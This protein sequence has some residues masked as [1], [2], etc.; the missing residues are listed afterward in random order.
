MKLWQELQLKVD[1]GETM[2]L[3]SKIKWAFFYGVGNWSFYKKE[4]NF[5]IM[6][7]QGLYYQIK[8]KELKKEKLGLEKKLENGLKKINSEK[9][10]SKSLTFL[11]EKLYLK[12][13]MRKNRKK[14]AK[15]ALWKQPNLFLEEYPIILSTTFSSIT[16]L[17]SEVVYDYLI[18]DEASQV[19]LATGSLALACAKNVVV[20]GDSKQLPNVIT[21][22][23]KKR[24]EEIFNSYKIA[25]G[26]KN[27]KS[28]LQSILEVIP[29]IPQVLLKEHY[30]CHPKII[31]FCNQKFYGGK[32]V[33][34]TED[35]G[36]KNV[37]SVL[38][39][40]E[41]NHERNHYSQRQVDV[42]KKEV[43]PTFKEDPNNIGIIAPYNN[44]VLALKKAIK[45]VEIATVHKFQ[46]REKDDIIIS[47][48]DDKVT[49]FSDDPCLLN[50]AISR[51]KKKLCVVVSGNEIKLDTNISDLISY[52]EY[53]NFEIKKSKI[54]SVFD[55]LYKQYT[56][57]RFEYLKKEKKISEFDS[58]NLLYSLLCEILK[59]EEF[60]GLD[61]ICHQPLNMLIS[62]YSLLD[63]VEKDYAMNLRT[64]LDFLLYKKID[65]KP[66][67]AIE[68]DG[69]K[70]HQ[71]SVVQKE[72]DMLK[73]AILEKY[74]IP[75]LR[76][77]TN[78]S[79]EKEKIIKKLEKVL[80]ITK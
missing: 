15:Y 18:I 39:T 9:I 78:E 49:D 34:M 70:Y 10:Q 8:L 2:S 61:I 20:V 73:N 1:L 31:N 76:L 28:F 42:I 33:I 48:V 44:Q 24:S 67:L 37:L 16:S 54:N 5:I 52:I 51:A 17:S 72:R 79:C 22:E 27:T 36:E 13:G 6:T 40:V 69:V 43:L 45:G 26:Y 19:D 62:D 32:L 53:N 12:Y 25:I 75:F 4:V 58:E 56:K 41:G 14:F 3:F 65:K 64:H 57:K 55:Y 38:K 50:V 46:G 29:N 47:T 21:E 60:M 30:R 7:L 35:H 77:S 11:R 71:M 23:N 63:S 80:S 68:V 59:K 66:L 74:K